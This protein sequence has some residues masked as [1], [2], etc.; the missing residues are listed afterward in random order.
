[1]TS[2]PAFEGRRLMKILENAGFEVTRVRGS[3]HFL[4]HV[5][6]RTTLI[7]VHAGETIGKG[8]FRKILKDCELTID[9]FIALTN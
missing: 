1:M 8:L 9:E 6:G 2:I 4:R 3:H 7:P 5:D